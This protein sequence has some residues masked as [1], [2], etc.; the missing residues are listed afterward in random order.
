MWLPWKDGVVICGCLVAV[1]LAIR[2]GLPLLVG[3]PTDSRL[4]TDSRWLV[5]TRTVA[6]EAA[7]VVGLYSVWQLAGTVSVMQVSGA[8]DRARWI[9]DVERWLHLPSE[10]TV[11]HL[12]LPHPWLVEA[13][14]SFYAIVHGPSMLL[15]L[16][17][18]FVRHRDRYPRAR[19]M[20]A[21]VTGACLAIQL[22]PVAPPRMLEGLGVVDTP[23]LYHQSVYD[24]LG[25]SLAYQLS[26]MPSVHVAWAVMISMVVIA[27]SSSRWRWLV[28]ADPILTVWAV[29]ATGNHFWLDGIVAVALIPVAVLVLNAVSSWGSRLGPTSGGGRE[30]DGDPTPAEG[31]G[32][33][34]ERDDVAVTASVPGAD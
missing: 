2:P 30:D 24:A 17:W 12:V 8:L 10:V 18:L 21:V 3:A 33:W 9:W 5:V 25:R 23:L 34:P 14:N 13:L 4:R 28:L 27:A 31:A 15:F 20:V 22:V 11:Q 6:S 7:V 29:V 32:P 19:N 16:V 1:A 26:A